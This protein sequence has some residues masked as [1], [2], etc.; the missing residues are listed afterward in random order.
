M[1]ELI[2]I[3]RYIAQAKTLAGRSDDLVE[4]WIMLPVKVAR[5]FIRRGVPFEELVAEGNL[6][7]VRAARDYPSSKAKAN[8][9]PFGAYASRAI[10]LHLEDR[11]RR[12]EPFKVPPKVWRKLQAYQETAGDMYRETGEVDEQALAD[13]LGLSR[14]EVALLR[15]LARTR[16]RVYSLEEELNDEDRDPDTRADVIPTETTAEDEALAQIEQEEKRERVKA[17]LAKLPPGLRRALSLNC[18][19]PLDETWRFE[20]LLR[21]APALNTMAVRARRVIRQQ[22][23][24]AGVLSGGGNLGSDTK[25]RMGSVHGTYAPLGITSQARKRIV[26]D[27]WDRLARHARPA[28]DAAG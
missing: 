28:V 7:L 18:G 17:L 2:P 27:I 13:Q 4:R 6:A 1:D 26:A 9:V 14:E 24:G 10:R 3:R 16:K 22:E 25:G 11:I 23:A 19:Y 5:E 8:G 20:D 12:E 15:H 21:L